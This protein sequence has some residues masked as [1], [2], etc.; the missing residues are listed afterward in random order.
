MDEM[1]WAASD[2]EVAFTK[3]VLNAAEAKANDYGEPVAVL[4]SDNQPRFSL[5]S[6]VSEPV[7]ASEC[8]E[9]VHPRWSAK[10][11]CATC[12]RTS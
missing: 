4:I 11:F 3:S 12:G 7:L 9:V 10:H 5:V 6:R 8:V 2:L 1:E